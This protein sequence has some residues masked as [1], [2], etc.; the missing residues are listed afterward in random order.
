MLGLNETHKGKTIAL[1]I[2]LVFLFLYLIT[3]LL[4]MDVYGNLLSPINAFICGGILLYSFLKSNR[5]VKISITFLMYSFACFAWGIADVLWAINV[6]EGNSPESI[7]VIWIIY[8]LTNFFVLISLL[9]FL[10]EQ[11]KKWDFVQF[12]ID[13]AASVS[14]II[15]VF[16]ILFLHKDISVLSN[17]VASDF[18]SLVSV[19]SDIL[20]CISVC[21]WFLSIRSGNAPMYI[22]II[23]FGL[24][25]FALVDIFYYYIEYHGLYVPNTM[26]DFTY[27]ASLYFI[28]IGALLKIFNNTSFCLYLTTNIGRRMRWA[29]LLFYPFI[30][31]IFSI[32]RLVDIRI[33]VSDIIYFAFLIFMY[34]GF[35]KYI[36]ISV[37]RE[38]CLKRKN[39]DLEQRLADQINELK[40]LANQDTLTALYNRRYFISSI[41]D[42]VQSAEQGN[43]MA[44]LLIDLDRFKTINDTYGHDVG[45]MVLSKIS[46]RM[47]EWN[48]YDATLARLG[49][50]EFAVMF[51]GKHT[52]KDIENYCIELIDL[53]SKP[54]DTG[55]LQLNP[56]MS[57]GVAL[58]TESA[59]DWKT[60]L[61][62]ADIAMYS[63]KSQG[64]NKYQFYDPIID[65]NFKQNIEIETLLKKADVNRDFKLFFQPQYSL[66]ELKL[67]GAE[68]LIRWENKEHG[69]IPPNVFIPIAEEIDYIFKLGKWVMQQTIQ[70]AYI[71]N[72][73]FSSELKVGFNISPRQLLDDEFIKLLEILISDVDI[74]PDWIDAEITESVMIKDGA[75]VRNVFKMLKKLGVSVSIDDFGSGYS[76]LSCINKYPYDRIKI[77][78]SLI[79]HVLSNSSGTNIVKA[80]I[81]MAHEN[82]IQVI[83]EG[84]ENNEQLEILTNLGCD[85]VQ[86]YL[87]GRPVPVDVFEKLY[88]INELNNK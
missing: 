23:S 30:V 47:I 21:S 39:E 32:T 43:L 71:W 28:A 76:S 64:Y 42:A 80:V 41:E 84:V 50:D 83:A 82:K 51:A 40:Y 52:Q 56:T 44:I 4:H 70:Q 86:G 31:I 25:M 11:F 22:R 74:D 87:L 48:K 45:D 75:Q 61:K 37:E 20:I 67:V 46:N 35:C 88:I 14:M 68:A 81:N 66:P 58:V 65:K 63:A 85:Q 17:L 19:F 49:G 55:S 29:Y 6:F 69:F 77:D 73:K 33:S 72:T 34:W 53:C 13:L 18:T 2:F 7:P 1:F 62:H 60:L 27:I 10:V 57:V 36:Q 24:V 59:C 26:I 3:S 15:M 9:I 16:W 79:D 38:S 54:I 8:F 5:T 12:A 78:K